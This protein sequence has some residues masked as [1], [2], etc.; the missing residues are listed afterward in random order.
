MQI[1]SCDNSL[2]TQFLNRILDEHLPESTFEDILLSLHIKSA[3][4]RDLH[5]ALIPPDVKE[6]NDQIIFLRDQWIAALL[7]EIYIPHQIGSVGSQSNSISPPKNELNDNPKYRKPISEA[8]IVEQWWHSDYFIHQTGKYAKN[9]VFNFGEYTVFFLLHSNEPR[10]SGKKA[11]KK[12]FFPVSRA[13][14]VEFREDSKQILVRFDFR[15]LS[16]GEIS[17]FRGKHINSIKKIQRSVI[18]ML[19]SW[20]PTSPDSKQW[21]PSQRESF[22]QLVSDH[23]IRYASPQKGLTFFYPRIRDTLL[24]HLNRFVES[25]LLSSLSLTNSTTSEQGRKKI[26]EITQL[27][28]DISVFKEIATSFIEIL[29]NLEQLK[30]QILNMPKYK[31]HSHFLFSHDQFPTS[32]QLSSETEKAISLQ[33][34]QIS[35]GKINVESSQGC[36]DTQSLSS[37]EYNAVLRYLYQ[38]SLEITGI[39]MKSDNYQA[40]QFLHPSFQKTIQTIYIDPPYNTGNQDFIYADQVERVNWLVFMD[41]RLSL[42]QTFLS[43]TGLFFSSIDDNELT[44]YSLV[45]DKIFPVKLDN[46]VWHKKT[47]PSYL[48]KELITVTEYI[49]AAKNTPNSIL[50]MGSLGNPLKLTELINIGNKVTQRILP[51][52][53]VIIQNGWSGELPSTTIY[54]RGKLQ[55]KIQGGP[56]NVVEGK[57][58]QDLVLEGRFKWLQSRLDQEVA[59]GGIIHIKSI[60]T[61]R[62]T[63]ARHYDSPIIKAPT[64]LLSKKVNEI[65]TNTDANRELKDL[66]GVSPFDY[67]KPTKLIKYLIRASTYNNKQAK[68]LDFFAGSGTTGHAV[69]SLNRD[70]GG[71]RQF[72]LIEKESLFDT[73]LLPRMKKLMHSA[74]WKNGKPVKSEAPSGSSGYDGIIEYYSLEQYGD[75]LLDLLPMLSVNSLSNSSSQNDINLANHYSSLDKNLDFNQNLNSLT[76][77][78]KL[79]PLPDDLPETQERK[80]HLQYGLRWTNRTGNLQIYPPLFEHPLHYWLIST[81]NGVITRKRVN[82][83]DSFNMWIGLQNYTIQVDTSFPSPVYLIRGFI[84]DLQNEDFLNHILIVWRDIAE[85][86]SHSELSLRN[87]VNTISKQEKIKIVY[88]NGRKLHGDALLI[89]PRMNSLISRM[90]SDL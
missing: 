25:S 70:D 62:P 45:V 52:E 31:F 66:F 53:H 63:I 78:I 90:A 46:I 59:K 81:E 87:L 2:L 79:Y 77:L 54:G 7:D 42:A 9:Y 24:H 6:T 88:C 28:A 13:E 15:H 69:F 26:G 56:V 35:C 89:A 1:S 60:K 19:D 36:I 16:P 34:A 14:F 3:V 57:P 17:N 8:H 47:Q 64:T 11:S 23:Y 38:K 80:F 50:M 4:F 49:L 32:L 74:D 27:Q 51:K 85:F 12:F 73:V 48:S 18:E 43:P 10:Q 40:L 83:I 76:D 84:T 37:Q 58:D 68:I 75:V 5:Q 29:S 21:N 72:I 39:C 65:P 22:K 61:L 71:H 41:Q 67:S 44:P 86:S 33:Q 30:L 55:I 20:I 82:L